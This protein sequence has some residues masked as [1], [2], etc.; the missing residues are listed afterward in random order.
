MP[1]FQITITR[2][3]TTSTIIDMVADDEE[4][5]KEEAIIKVWN[6]SDREFVWEP[7]DPGF[8]DAEPYITDVVKL[9]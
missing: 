8:L 2:K 7:D 6:S 9:D 4:E 3:I 1:N 5:A